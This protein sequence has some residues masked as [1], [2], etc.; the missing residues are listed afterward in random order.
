MRSADARAAVVM[1]RDDSRRVLSR[2]ALMY[3][4][5]SLVCTAVALY[6]VYN[7]L[8]GA[9]GAI[10]GAV[11]FGAI[12]TG[13]GF[14]AIAAVRDLATYPMSS[15]GVVL[16]A[17][18]KGTVFW[19]SRAYY[20]LVATPSPTRPGRSERR[21]F[22]VT[23]LAH[24]AVRDDRG[25]RQNELAGMRRAAV[26]AEGRRA[27]LNIEQYVSRAELMTAI[28]DRDESIEIEH[29]PHTNTVIRASLLPAPRPADSQGSSSRSG[30]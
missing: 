2:M 6:S 22:V 4:P 27:G 15:R 10:V 16:R 12:G 7:I 3:V 19:L 9:L 5:S 30:L 13:L 14:Q 28:E 18:N 25:R 17:W 23:R 11:L 21:V 8:Q 29:W 1:E 26:E 24:D 20:L